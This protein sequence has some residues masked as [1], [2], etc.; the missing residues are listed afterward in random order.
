MNSA[1]Y[2]HDIS[3]Y[4]W[5][6]LASLL[7]GRRGVGVDKP[8]IIDFLLTQFFGFCGQELHGEIFRQ[9]MVTGKI[10]I[11]VFVV[12]VITAHGSISLQS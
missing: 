7:P 4:V 5:I 8:K 10:L 12:G 1:I 11:V 6:L 2:L 3:D 9:N